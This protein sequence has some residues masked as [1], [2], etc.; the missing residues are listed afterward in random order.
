MQT[1]SS[2]K[3]GIWIRSVKNFPKKSREKGAEGVGTLSKSGM[4][5][6][7]K[8]SKGGGF[9]RCWKRKRIMI[10]KWISGSQTEV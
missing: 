10:I 9:W 7:R 2:R 3:L 6:S 4:Y 8:V 1:H 5:R